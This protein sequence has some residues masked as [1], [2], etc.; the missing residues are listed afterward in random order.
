MYYPDLTPLG[1]PNGRTLLSVGFLEPGH[2]FTRGPIE[3]DVF[4]AI[5][6]LCLSEPSAASFGYYISPF[7]QEKQ[8]YVLRHGS[9]SR[10]L[11]SCSMLVPG[12]GGTDYLA[13]DLIYHYIKD[14]GYL[15]PACFLQA[16]RKMATDSSDKT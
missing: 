6:R 8:P 16:V 3:P 1:N 12:E 15:P 11:G 5:L 13:P 10:A 7:R 9:E 14:L 4:A 2:E